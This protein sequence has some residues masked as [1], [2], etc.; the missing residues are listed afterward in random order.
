MTSSDPL[1]KRQS[2]E[3]YSDIGFIASRE[4][5][6][7]GCE[8]DQHSLV[9]LRGI[10]DRYCICGSNSIIITAFDFEYWLEFPKR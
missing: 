9:P 10:G 2:V 8:P 3:D 4:Q 5:Q 6:E 7:G 1:P